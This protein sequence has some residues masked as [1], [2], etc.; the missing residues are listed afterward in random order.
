MVNGISIF[1]L[2]IIISTNKAVHSSRGGYIDKQRYMTLMTF[3]N[4][5]DHNL[6]LIEF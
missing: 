4:R 5:L 1:T 2:P 6:T 3:L